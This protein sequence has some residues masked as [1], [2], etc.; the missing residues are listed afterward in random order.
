MAPAPV[1]IRPDRIVPL[2][3]ESEDPQKDRYDWGP[4][5]MLE[6]GLY[7]MWWV[8]LGGE[9]KQRFAYATTLPDGERFEFTYPDW[10]DRVYYAESRDGL[11]WN[12]TGP[13][14]AGPVEQFGPDAPGPLMVLAPAES[15][16]EKHHIGNPSVIKVDGT[17]YMYYETCSEYIVRRD[18]A[19]KIVVG[20]EYHNQVF[21]ATSKD[22]KQWRKHP[23][24]R[25]PTP[26]VVAPSSNKQGRQRYG[27]GQPSV[28]FRDGRYVMH[29]VDACNGPGD[30]MVRVEADDPFFSTKRVFRHRLRPPQ[31]WPAV[32]EGAVSR[33]AQT[34]IK[35]LGQ[36]HLLVRSAYEAGT[37]GLMVSGSGVFAADAAAVTPAKVYPQIAVSDPRGQTYRTRL[38]PRFLT[39]PQGQVLVQDGK[40]AICYASGLGF[41]DKAYTWDLFRCDV[42]VGEIEKATGLRL[43]AAQKNPGR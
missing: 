11:K 26:I 12:I 32:P 38:F 14:F 21:V 16:Q 1:L 37:L 4:S 9:N 27:L 20:D 13:D 42:A 19:G 41:K 24:D 30:F 22:G 29:Y 23:D 34:D 17:Y 28:F 2:Q 36:V 5:V 15:A 3:H 39:D 33:F 8:R 18:Q 43:R 25:A 10:G 6:D 7:K 40:V 31:G 35:Y